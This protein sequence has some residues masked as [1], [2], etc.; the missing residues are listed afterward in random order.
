MKAE[1][2][3]RD[4]ILGLAMIKN[5]KT[6]DPADP[7]SPSVIQIETAMGAAIEIF[8][9]ATT[10]EVG[11]DRFVPVK[12]TN[13]LLV[14]RSDCYELDERSVLHQVPDEIPFVDLGGA[15]K[16]VDDFDRRFPAG[17]PSLR[18]ATSMSVEGDWTFGAGIAC[19][20]D[21]AVGTDGSP[22]VIADGTRLSG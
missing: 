18:D 1:L 10:I 20:G 16:L 19:V 7:S 8:E 14:L 15:Y 2:D 9:G 21:V 6:V 22:G 4:G 12:T 5:A 13:D 11:R 3:R 17:V